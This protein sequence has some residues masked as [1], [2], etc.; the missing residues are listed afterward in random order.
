[1]FPDE[2]PTPNRCAVVYHRQVE[3]EILSGYAPAAVPRALPV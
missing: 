2:T 1:M 3:T